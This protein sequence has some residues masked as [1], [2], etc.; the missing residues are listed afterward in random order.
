MYDL[1]EPLV[2]FCFSIVSVLCAESRLCYTSSIMSQGH[3]YF[4]FRQN[5]LYFL[6][7][8]SSSW[9]NQPHCTDAEIEAQTGEE[10]CPEAHNPQEMN[11]NLLTSSL[12]FFLL[13]QNQLLS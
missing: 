9:G 12:E 10:T 5:F 13:C 4:D 6:N 8:S 2:L 7:C 11:R 3:V 1:R